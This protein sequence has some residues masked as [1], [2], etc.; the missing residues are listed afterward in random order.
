MEID[1]EDIESLDPPEEKEEPW[2]YTCHAFTDYRRK[3]D[4]FNRADLNG[5]SYPEIVEVPHCIKCDHSM[6]LISTSRKLVWSVNFLALLTWVVGLLCVIILFEFTFG[7][8][9]GLLIH[10]SICYLLSRLPKKSRLTL[11]S[12][13]KAKKENA[14][15]E[16]LQKI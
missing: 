5:G 1:V 11:T 6:F 16:L 8:C 15:R 13:K 12:W 9:I 14:V 4:T 2:C 10:G 7:S 3:W